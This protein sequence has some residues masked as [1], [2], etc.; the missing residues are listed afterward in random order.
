MKAQAG[1]TGKGTGG[2]KFSEL[3]ARISKAP[4]KKKPVGGLTYTGPRK[5]TKKK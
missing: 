3:P 4:A 1:K 5:A 2:R